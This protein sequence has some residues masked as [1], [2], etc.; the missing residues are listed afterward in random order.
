M[1]NFP[2]DFVIPSIG[3]IG[4]E[5]MMESGYPGK[6]DFQAPHPLASRCGHVTCFDEYPVSGYDLLPPHLAYCL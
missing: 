3:I 2:T 5:L 6:L 1:S 4:T